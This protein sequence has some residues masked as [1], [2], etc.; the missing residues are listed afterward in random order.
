MLIV[1]AEAVRA[2]CDLADGVLACLSCRGMLV[3]IHS[4]PL[5]SRVEQ[6]AR[7]C[8]GASGQERGEK[9]SPPMGDAVA[10]NRAF[11]WPREG[12]IPWPTLTRLVPDGPSA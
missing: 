8:T 12:R 1:S 7:R 4:G 3:R 6:N 5:R 9:L 11:R 2:E 10:N